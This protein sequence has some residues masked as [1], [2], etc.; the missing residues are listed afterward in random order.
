MTAILLSAVM[1]SS[2]LAFSQTTVNAAVQN[3][4]EQ[5]RAT[6]NYYINGNKAIGW[7]Y[8]NNNW[9]YM[10]SNGDMATGWIS[11]GGKSYY[12]N[13]NGSMAVNTTTPDGYVVGADGAWNGQ[14]KKQD[15]NNDG[16]NNKQESKVNGTRTLGELRKKISWSDYLVL[17]DE[18]LNYGGDDIHKRLEKYGNYLLISVG[19]SDFSTPDDTIIEPNVIINGK[20]AYSIMVASSS[21]YLSA[22]GRHNIRF[23]GVDG[24]GYTSNEIF[25]AMENNKIFYVKSGESWAVGSRIESCD[26]VSFN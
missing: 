13:S 25:E 1:I 10:K 8:I 14:A 5:N 17:T 23:L 2:T 20:L 6:W 3:G 22:D 18:I 16:A 19:D 7:Q 15:V 11:D 9:Y 12:L 4:W 26:D 21:R 24:R